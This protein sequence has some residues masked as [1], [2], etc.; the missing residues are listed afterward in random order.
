MLETTSP[1]TR[2]KSELMHPRESSSLST[3]PTEEL[4]G[5]T[6]V[7]TSIG[8]PLAHFELLNKRMGNERGGQTNMSL[9]ETAVNRT[10]V[11]AS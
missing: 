5:D 3:S 6:S 4:S 10:G 2:I 8:F 7:C 9:V 1:L 11:L